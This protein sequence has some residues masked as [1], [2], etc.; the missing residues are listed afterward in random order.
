M[1]AS[2]VTALEAPPRLRAGLRST[3]RSLRNPGHRCRRRAPSV[4]VGFTYRRES[5]KVR[6]PFGSDTQIE[7]GRRSDGDRHAIVVD[8]SRCR[9]YETWNTRTRDGRWHAGSGAVWDL[10]SNA[11][12]HD[13]WTSADAAGLPILPGLLRWREVR[14][15]QGRPRHPLHDRR[16]R[17]TLRL[18]GPPPGRIG[19]TTVATHPWAPA[20]G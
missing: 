8:K 15:G 9:L 4:N 7:G 1:D 2:H 17:P 6:Y 5:D 13:G 19:A 20:S 18:A 3:A 10:G 12:R 11:L 14:K 16:H